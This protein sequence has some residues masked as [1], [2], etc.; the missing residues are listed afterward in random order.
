MPAQVGTFEP[1]QTEPNLLGLSFL[2]KQQSPLL[3]KH[4]Q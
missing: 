2:E 4:T 3:F 1:L